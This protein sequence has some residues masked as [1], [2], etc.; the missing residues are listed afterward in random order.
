MLLHV[1]GDFGVEHQGALPALFATDA[2]DDGEVVGS[3]GTVATVILVVGGT[4]GVGYESSLDG[5]GCVGR[6]VVIEACHHADGHGDTLVVA[7][8]VT[9][10][11]N[12]C[13]VTRTDASSYMEVAI[14]I[15]PCLPTQAM[16]VEGTAVVKT[17]EVALRL[18]AKQCFFFFHLRFKCHVIP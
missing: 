5:F 12:S 7:V 10:A 11:V 18:L 2:L 6:H 15:L 3:D 13:L 9:M 1:V 8:L 17:T 4:A 14:I 16:V